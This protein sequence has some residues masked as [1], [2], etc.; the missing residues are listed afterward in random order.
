M[1]ITTL[2]VLNSYK[3]LININN[4]IHI[5]K[6]I[7]NLSNEEVGL[8]DTLDIIDNIL[9]MMFS[10]FHHYLNIRKQKL[11][12]DS[13][14]KLKIPLSLV[15][16]SCEYSPSLALRPCIPYSISIASL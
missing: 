3:C 5:N 1:P 14:S 15:L 13:Y 8:Y 4:D 6:D 16:R 2:F 12:W 7:N 9:I 11:I 10:S